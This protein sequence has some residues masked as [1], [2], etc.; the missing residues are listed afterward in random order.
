MA[1][2]KRPPGERLF[3]GMRTEAYCQEMATLSG[4]VPTYRGK[5]KGMKPP[6]DGEVVRIN[7]AK[8]EAE[9]LGNDSTGSSSSDQ[10]SSDRQTARL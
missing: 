9:K 6:R 10:S 3:L 1:R 2:A 7:P 4:T 8:R 5:F